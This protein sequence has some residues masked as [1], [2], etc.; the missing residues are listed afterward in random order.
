[1]PSNKPLCMCV[2]V[3]IY[4]NRNEY[5]G[6]RI[7]LQKEVWCPTEQH[8]HLQYHGQHHQRRPHGLGDPVRMTRTR[9]KA[10]PTQECTFSPL[11][12]S[13]SCRLLGTIN[14]HIKENKEASVGEQQGR[15][16]DTECRMSHSP[17]VGQDLTQT[18]SWGQ[19]SSGGCE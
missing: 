8:K 14:S 2:S 18:S 12:G 16:A 5:Y 6:Y 11:T 17:D 13:F 9:D 10:P 7:S 4:R 15:W 3:Y 1:M 19:R